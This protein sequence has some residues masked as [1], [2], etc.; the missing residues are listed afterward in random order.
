MS[1]TKAMS[2]WLKTSTA[3]QRAA[4]R[5]DLQAVLATER[6]PMRRD[7]LQQRIRMIDA[8]DLRLAR[9]SA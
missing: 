5:N 2:A 1:A 4:K 8:Y 3:E 9:P 6:N 7:S